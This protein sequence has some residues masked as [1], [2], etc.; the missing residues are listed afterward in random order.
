MPYHAAMLLSLIAAADE[1]NV[2]GQDNKIPWYLPDDWKYFRAKTKG[3][4]IIMGRKTYES[5][6]RP[7]PDRLNIVI[8]R[9]ADFKA[10]GCIVVHSL[11]DAVELAKRDA[12]D[13]V[14]VIGGQQI[15]EAAMPEADRI[16]LT[17]VHAHIGSGH[18]HFP[19]MRFEEWQ[20]TSREDHAADEKHVF[21]FSYLTYERVK[22]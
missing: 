10:E 6:G 3:H 1:N 19:D 7:L 16:Y 9:N 20:E 14:F 2:I 8:S 17:R 11:H 13:E 4:P 12:T 21:P 5:I 22:T 15:Y 18:A